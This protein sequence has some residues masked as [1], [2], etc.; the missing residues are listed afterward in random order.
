MA[1][2]VKPQESVSATATATAAA[3]VID[4]AAVRA[5]EVIESA[6]GRAALLAPSDHDAV[7]RLQGTVESLAIVVSR[8]ETKVDTING[9]VARVTE[10]TTHIEEQIRSAPQLMLDHQ[11]LMA[12]LRSRAESKTDRQWLIPMLISVPS[13]V[14]SLATLVTLFVYVGG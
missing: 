11:E 1:P 10:R 9:G 6:A 7:I 14:L 12:D 2:K 13:S 5:A 8:V 3:E 4:R